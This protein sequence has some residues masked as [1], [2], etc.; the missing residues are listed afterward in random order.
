MALKYDVSVLA[1]NLSNITKMT[2]AKK[3][4]LQET[5]M[6]KEQLIKLKNVTICRIQ[7]CSVFG[8]GG[9]YKYHSERKCVRIPFFISL[10]RNKPKAP[11]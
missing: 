7:L 9:S 3:S 4:I 6:S 10:K 1:D 11:I 5:K 8:T 2:L